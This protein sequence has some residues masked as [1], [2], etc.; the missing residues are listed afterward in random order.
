MLPLIF[1]T[2]ISLPL[3]LR[4]D[5][6]YL[7]V[8]S[9]EYIFLIH[10]PMPILSYLLNYILENIP[11]PFRYFSLNF[12]FPLKFTGKKYIKFTCMPY[13]TFLFY[14][15]VNTKMTTILSVT[16]KFG[17]WGYFVLLSF[18]YFVI[19]LFCYFITSCQTFSQNVTQGGSTHSEVPFGMVLINIGERDRAE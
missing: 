11:T 3:Y 7:L 13:N 12:P 17:S 9:F 2:K 18:C 1:S 4:T 8:F 14:L 19:F 5:I 16:Y 15:Q 6:S 10:F